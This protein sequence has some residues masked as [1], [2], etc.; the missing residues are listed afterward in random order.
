METYL[1]VGCMSGTSL[2]GLDLVACRFTADK[3]W[4]FEI[5]KAVTI[6][7]SHKWVH[8]LSNAAG[9]NALEFALLH[10]EFGKFIGKQVADFCTDLPENPDLVSSHGHT[11]FHQ[12]QERLTLQIGNGAFI[13]AY[14]GLPTACDFRSLDVALKGQGA[15]LV[16]IGDELLF[17]KYEICLNLGGIAN[18]SFREEDQRK[19]FDIC[20]VNMAL[21]HFIKELGYEY[22]LDGNLGRTGKVQEE[23][24]ALLNEL[25][26]Y[27]QK[28]PK[29]LGREWFEEEFLPL[30]S[31]FQLAPEDILRTLYE[32]I[33]DQLSFAV[34]QYPK[35]QI[36]ITGGGAHNVF[37]IELFSEKTKHK[38]I[39]PSAQIIDFKEAIIFAFLGVLRLREDVNCLKSVTGASRDHSGGVIYRP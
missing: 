29:S 20:P 25:E 4:K 13:A 12:P 30:I 21:N 1:S 32:H 17:G 7:Y 16:P 36:L 19:A 39:I 6:F 26:F 14:S 18:V 34:D 5:L 24:L 23:L 2:D 8:K 27:Q 11:I 15:P 37:L 9:L 35:G 28:G 10:N 38:T 3:E 33:S 31:S 22:D